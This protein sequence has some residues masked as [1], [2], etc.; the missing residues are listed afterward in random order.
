[1]CFNCV[2]FVADF[3][4]TTEL[5]CVC[6]CSDDCADTGGERGMCNMRLKDLS[7]VSWEDLRKQSLAAVVKI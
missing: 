3:S 5:P 6:V 7:N 1:M 2:Q 4:D